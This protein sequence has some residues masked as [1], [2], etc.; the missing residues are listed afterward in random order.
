MRAVNLSSLTRQREPNTGARLTAVLFAIK[1]DNDKLTHV[2]HTLSRLVAERVDA[3]RA[4]LAVPTKGCRLPLAHGALQVL[5]LCVKCATAF[6]EEDGLEEVC[7]DVVKLCT[8][9]IGTLLVVVADTAASAP[10][11]EEEEE[12]RSACNRRPCNDS[13]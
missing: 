10:E 11:E 7:E 9:A 13:W 1:E 6:S 12:E 5:R 4:F 8:Q 2:L 3:A